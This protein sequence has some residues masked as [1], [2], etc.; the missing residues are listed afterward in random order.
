MTNCGGCDESCCRSELV[1]GGTFDRSYDLTDAG[2]PS[3]PPDGAP[4]NEQSPATISF[5][6]LD[7]YL[8]TVGR[9]RQFVAAWNNGAGYVPPAGSGKHAHLNDGRGLADSASPGTYEPGWLASDDAYVDP[10]ATN[11]DCFPGFSS[12]TTAAGSQENMPINCVTW[13][14]AFAFCIW[15]GGFLPSE[16]EWVFAAAGGDEQRKYP[17]G[18]AAPGIGSAYA[19]YGCDFPAAS[20]LCT[21]LANMADVGTSMRGSSRWGQLDMAG[22]VYEWSLDWYA[23]YV[24]PCEDCAFATLGSNRVIHGGYFAYDATYLLPA[25]RGNVPVGQR[26]NGV[27]FRCARTP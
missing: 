24:D 26:V 25:N 14:E 7:R 12:W 19:V 17:W 13:Q 8:V 6:R 2:D 20:G 15:D 4:S 11:L 21:G 3:P 23:A 27:G 22:E 9:F 16:A 1:Q 10:T 18:A 5:F